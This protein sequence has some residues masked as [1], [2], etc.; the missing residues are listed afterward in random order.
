[1]AGSAIKKSYFVDDYLDHDLIQ[2]LIDGQKPKIDRVIIHPDYNDTTKNH[3]IAIIKLKS[4]LS[5]NQYVMPAAL[6]SICYASDLCFEPDQREQMAVVSGWGDV[7]YG[8]E[9]SFV[10]STG[11]P[12]RPNHLDHS[13]G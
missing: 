12:E 3:D 4:S 11:P 13:L 7:C 10:F 9:H 5:F 2:G 8:K 1:M 6:P